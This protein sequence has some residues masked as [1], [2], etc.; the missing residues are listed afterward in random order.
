MHTLSDKSCS[1]NVSSVSIAFV[2]YSYLLNVFKNIDEK[3]SCVFSF[4]VSSPE[5]SKRNANY[6]FLIH[7]SVVYLS[8]RAL[9]WRFKKTDMTLGDKNFA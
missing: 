8:E 9:H 7:N 4:V 1:Q 5:A 6:K 2:M 3:D